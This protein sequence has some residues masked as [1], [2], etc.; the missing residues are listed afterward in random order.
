MIILFCTQFDHCCRR[1]DN[2][3]VVAYSTYQLCLKQLYHK[4]IFYLCHFRNRKI[5]DANIYFKL[6]PSETND[7]HT[8]EITCGKHSAMVCIFCNSFLIS[9]IYSNLKF[10]ANWHI[11]TYFFLLNNRRLNIFHC[12]LSLSIL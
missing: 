12:W 9:F 11:V 4:G 2:S 1:N 5:C 6:N 3:L 8:F 10:Q 7:L